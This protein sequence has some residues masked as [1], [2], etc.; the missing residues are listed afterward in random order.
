[1]G[2]KHIE[3]RVDSLLVSGQPPGKRGTRRG[4]K[5]TFSPAQTSKRGSNWS[6]VMDDA[7]P[8]LPQ[9][10]SPTGGEAASKEIAAQ[11]ATI[12]AARWRFVSPVIP[13]TSSTM[14]GCQRFKLSD[15][16]NPRRYLW[17][18]RGTTN[19]SGKNHE[20][21]L[22]L[23][24]NAYGRCQRTG[25][26]SSMPAS[27]ATHHPPRKQ[28]CPGDL[29]MA[30]PEVG[31]RY[32]RSL[33]ICTRAGQVLDTGHRLLHKMD[34][35]LQEWCAEQG[36]EQ[37][38]TSVHHPQGNGQVE[39]ANRSIMEGI[40]ARLDQWGHS[41]VDE[42]PHVLWAHRTSPK[43]SNGET[44]FSLTYGSEAVIPAKIGVPSARALTASKNDNSQEIRI[45]LDLLD[46]RRKEA[47]LQEARYKKKL[48]KYYNARV[49]IC[50]FNVDDYVLRDNEASRV[51]RPGKLSPNWEGP[52]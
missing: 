52:Y 36:I 9:H 19:D 29:G 12:P 20:R 40:K 37:I 3:A 2:A 24:W 14:R 15:K 50:K 16:G 22:L 51:K 43:T 46:K 33:P 7:Y 25:Q 13:G 5:H 11:C 21:R 18:A 8:E 48:E 41:W 32:C 35:K 23:A 28:T 6:K 10:R 31:N 1:M 42:L 4:P 38:F 49:K 47:A 27:R 34:R 26:M 44:P 17:Y 30:L 39:R 45:N